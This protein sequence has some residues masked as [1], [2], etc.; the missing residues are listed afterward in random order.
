MN[1]ECNS[2]ISRHKIILDVKINQS[3][4]LKIKYP[5][6]VKF[7]IFTFFSLVLSLLFHC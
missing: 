6:E 7:R 2:T 5:K 3:T 1:K 4:E